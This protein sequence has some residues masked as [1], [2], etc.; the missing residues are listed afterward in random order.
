[1]VLFWVVGGEY[2][3]GPRRETVGG[4]ERWFGPFS[5]YESARAECA[6]HAWPGAEGSAVRYRVACIDPDEVPPCTD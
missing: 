5:N 3:D 2:T 1:M 6:R 4:N